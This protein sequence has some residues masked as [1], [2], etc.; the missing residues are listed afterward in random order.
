M[1]YQALYRQYRPQTFDEVIGQ[2]HIVTTLINQINSKRIGHAYLFTGSRGIGKTTCARIFARAINCLEPING[3]PCGKCKVC[4]AYEENNMDIIEIDAAS[5]NKVEEVRDIREKVKYPP[6]NGKYKVYI[7]DEVHMLTE[8]A[9][10]A[11]LKT[12]E[13]PPA[14][15]VFIL[16][17]TEAHKLPATILSRCMRFDFKLVTT[18]ALT[19]LLKK[20]FDKN[21]VGYDEK[22]VQAIAA[23]AEGGV[24]DALSISDCAISFGKGNID[25]DTVVNI[26]GIGD[27]EQ[28]SILV[29]NILKGD[30]GGVLENINTAYLNGKNFAVFGKELTNYF[31]NL[32]VIKTCNNPNAILNQ[33]EEILQK[34][35]E[36]AQKVD[37]DKLLTYMEKFS[38]I[39]TD[40][41]YSLS[42]KTLIA[43]TCLECASFDPSKKS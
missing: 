27:K 35:K 11:L 19:K 1:S 36:Q 33:P 2:E 18:E 38:N 6:I 29:D 9:F 39:E 26:L 28:V 32:I 4:K 31:K 37:V 40:L 24:R 21:K 14:H 41:K 8:S 5:N 23:A 17:T 7:I 30:L 43:L 25:Y 34:Y 22:S 13:E 10:N 16:A 15:A 12:L 20:I 42:P 3:S